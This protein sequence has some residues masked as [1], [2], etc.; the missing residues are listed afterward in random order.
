[1]YVIIMV[2]D[3]M[4]QEVHCSANVTAAEHKDIIIGAKRDSAAFNMYDNTWTF[5]NW[6]SNQPDN[7]NGNENCVVSNDLKG[8][9]WQDTD[10]SLPGYIICQ[11]D[12]TISTSKNYFNEFI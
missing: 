6:Y 5:S 4:L 2:R 3:S 11:L 10:C 9:G 1:M 7:A 12:P 8:Y